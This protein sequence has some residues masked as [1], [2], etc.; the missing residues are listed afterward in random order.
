M[1]IHSLKLIYRNMKNN[2]YLFYF[3][4]PTDT[5][6]DDIEEIEP[7]SGFMNL[8]L[9]D[10]VRARLIMVAESRAQDDLVRV[11]FFNF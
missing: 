8:R 3:K 6:D 7:P 11:N 4:A 9:V 1:E 5:V 2:F 10:P